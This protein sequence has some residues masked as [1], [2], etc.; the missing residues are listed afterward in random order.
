MS[1]EGGGEGSVVGDRVVGGRLDVRASSALVSFPRFCLFAVYLLV[2]LISWVG[3]T[4][5]KFRWVVGGMRRR[6]CGCR[7]GGAA[8]RAW[9][10]VL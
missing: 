6:D 4:Y 9:R 1:G 5:G 2:W 10:L 7:L 3:W 8:I